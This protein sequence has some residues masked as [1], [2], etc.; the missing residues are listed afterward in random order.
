MRDAP[1]ARRSPFFIRVTDEDGFADSVEA[2]FLAPP[3][4]SSPPPSPPRQEEDA[5]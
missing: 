2:V 5:R 4:A 3:P 1:G